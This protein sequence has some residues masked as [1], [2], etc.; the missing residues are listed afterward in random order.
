MKNFK[1]IMSLFLVVVMALSSF[2]CG[3]GSG[4]GSVK[5]I[6]LASGG[7]S[8]T[9]YGFSGAVA[10]RLNEVLN[11]DMR[12]NVVS[13][14][15]SK[16]NAQMIDSNDAQIAII[17]NDVM[18]YA[19]KA[20]D[21]FAGQKPMN[22]FSAIASAY[23]ESIQIIAN[24]SI[25]SID[26]L[27]GKKVSVGDAG[28]GTEFNA[29]QILEAYGMD[30]NKDIVKDNRSFADSCD[31]LKN[32]NLDAAFITAGHPTVAVTELATNFDFNI[33]PVDNE[34]VN[35]LMSKYQFYA[36]VNIEK[37]TYTVLTSDVPTVAVMATFI[38]NNSLDED[39]VYKFTKT[40]FDEKANIIH[41][42]AALLDKNTA[43]QGISIPFHKGAEKYYKEQGVLK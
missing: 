22:S 34:H 37:E 6:T 25:T 23:P 35:K 33:L 30:I 29:K 18:D 2:A 15:A 9:Y 1:K 8:G 10:S 16:I 40:L 36:K 7:T 27:K 11:N 5:K 20:T 14:G 24:K 3:N 38:A 26:Q 12:I 4:S 17:Q 39:T 41:Q 31:G 19:Y 32:G 28:S 43:V 13:T 21:M 42:K